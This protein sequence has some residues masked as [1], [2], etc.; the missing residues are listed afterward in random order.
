MIA[1]PP[2]FRGVMFGEALAACGS[3]PTRSCV[4]TYLKNLKDFTANGLQSPVTPFECT[5]VNYNGTKWCWKH[6]FYRTVIIRELGTP[7]QGLYAF[8]RVYPNSGFATDTLHVVRGT[9]Y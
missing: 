5:K 6:I 1:A 3:A 7:S 8:R 2:L 4:M 9:P